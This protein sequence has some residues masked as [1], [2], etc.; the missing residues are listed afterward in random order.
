VAIAAL[1][2]A[3]VDLNLPEN[4][5]SAHQREI[6]DALPVL[7][8][9][10]RAGRIVFA[11]AEARQL[12]GLD[13]GEWTPRPVEEVLWGLFPGTAEPQIQLNG[14]GRGSPFNATMPA[15]SGRLLPVEGTYC[16][17]NAELREAVI[18]AHP[19][20][21]ER[22]PK[23]RLMEDVLA[24]MPEAV[25]ILHDNHV[26]YT[27]PA[28]TRLFGYT[29]E[30][31][32]GRNLREL[33]VPQTRQ[34]E[35]AML[36]KAIDRHGRT[37][38]ETVR[39]NKKDELVDVAVMAGPL[40]VDDA[41]VGYV[42]T[43]REIGERKQV[44]AKLQYDALHDVLTGLPNRALFQD[45][46]NLAL[47]R[48]L[49]RRDQSCGML[50]LDLDRFKEIN[51]SLGRAAGD[52]LLVS[53]SERLCGALRPQDSAA[54]LGA[55]EFGIL[56]ENIHAAG[57]L[58]IVAR[59]VM[60]EMER[61]FEIYGH[62]VRVSVSIGVAM[63][64]PEHTAPELLIQDADLAMYRAKEEGGG[65]YE[66]FHKSL[67]V[68]VSGRQKRERELHQVLNQQ[69]VE[70]WYQPIYRL[71]SGRLVGFE[72][73]L[74][75]RQADGSV[76]SFH[77]L[78][79]VA[80]ETGL[81]ISIGRE[82]V[83]AVCRQLRSASAILP[84]ADLTVSVNVTHRQF[85]NPDMVAQLKRALTVTGVDPSR[86]V[87]EVQETTLNEN[88]DAAVAILQR[89]IDCNVRIALDNFGSSLAPLNHLFRL[90]LDVVKLDPRLTL[91]ATSVGRQQAVLESII[92][93]G[94]TLGM[95]M[96][97]QGIETPEQMDALRRM[98]CELGQGG[99]L[100][101]ALEAEAALKL[102]GTSYWAITPEA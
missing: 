89:M 92:Q 87:L 39:K 65:R 84:Q 24:S 31:V 28:F 59:R 37:L 57:D 30:E 2:W 13:E 9:L 45:R 11:N 16:I 90:P 19:G 55:D 21:R 77:D 54:R 33:I 8:F 75:C 5:Y 102:V 46:L 71:L 47:T 99:V 101:C 23:S 15:R 78:L 48:Q 63:A 79:Q 42:L 98:G 27:N 38:I 88:P 41:P 22:A 7:V 76:D 67:K 34:H 49:R 4:S 94:R 95:P 35:H 56:V 96:V 68:Q 61:P 32:S 50:L 17:L 85:Y 97:A 52:R 82:T 53:L 10:E 20:G 80:E 91:V 100:S 29:A 18:V 36:A 40:M 62:V 14:I 81:S 51:D 12:L 58:E 69:K 44:E 70:I 3:S 1:S 83:D 86:L 64:G 73:V 93:L 60:A 66:I 74:R 6:L 25:A 26:L 72:S 43:Y